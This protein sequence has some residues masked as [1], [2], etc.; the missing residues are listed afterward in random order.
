M[1]K[2]IVM[3][4][5]PKHLIVMTSDGKF[6]KLSRKDRSC[7][8]GEEIQ[9]S[10]PG[11][12]WNKPSKT[13]ASALIAAVLFGMIVFAGLGSFLNSNQ[14]VAYVSVDINPSV[15]FGI[16]ENE[17][18][19]EAY[20]LNEDG[21]EL[22]KYI[23]F[24]GKFLEEV[25]TML[26]TEANLR[27]YFNKYLQYHEGTI[28]ITSTLMSE[29]TLFDEE[30]AALKVKKSLENVIK[31]KHPNEAENFAVTLVPTSKEIREEAQKQ[32]KSTGKLAIELLSKE[33]E[34]I[35]SAESIEGLS[36]HEAAKQLGGI[37]KLIQ[38]NKAE[39]RVILNGL[40]KIEKEQKKEQKRADKETDK[41]AKEA[42]KENKK[43]SQKDKQQGNNVLPIDLDKLK[44]KPSKIDR[45]EKEH[46][47]A[48]DNE[49]KREKDKEEQN[50]N[51][52]EKKNE[53]NNKDKAKG[54]EQE[55]KKDKDKRH[56][57]PSKQRLLDFL[58]D[59]LPPGL[60]SFHN[61][62]TFSDHDIVIP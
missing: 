9:F 10:A 55:S 7:R 27:G 24:E 37:G 11:I 23:D 2:G 40:L 4:M 47:K 57:N 31:E 1:N 43:N 16:D 36:I 50:K 22:M 5:A 19:I 14:V 33:H 8:I 25:S 45:T 58:G 28:V 56:S 53:G 12:L 3:E 39:T 13:I 26:M 42:E 48:E 41:E 62:K 44:P 34:D 29:S 49:N 59:K 21:K 52:Q 61:K 6:I 60:A 20:G 35:I 18:V 15:E 38:S 17:K 46:E 51:N 30:Q 54:N 32:G